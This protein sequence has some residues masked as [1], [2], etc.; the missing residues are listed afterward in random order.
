MEGIPTA[1]LAQG[2]GWA[3][4][5]AAVWMVLTGRL[6]PRSVMED[7]RTDRDRW[8][9][10]HEVS[11]EARREADRQ[12]GELLELARTTGQALSSLPPA[13]PEGVRADA[14]PGAVAGRPSSSG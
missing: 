11:E 5:A 1:L 7:A 8:R 2:G 14:D 12:M 6:V 9:A 13:P 4:V 3:I 10:A